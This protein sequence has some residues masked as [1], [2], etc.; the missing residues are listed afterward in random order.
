[1]LA[2]DIILEEEKKSIRCGNRGTIE[3]ER[4]LNNELDLPV[5]INFFFKKSL[6]CGW[7]QLKGTKLGKRWAAAK[8][9]NPAPQTALPIGSA[10]AG[11]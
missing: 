10:A 5:Y 4:F 1:M 9:S 6:I 2:K 7:D 11:V 3:N 8:S